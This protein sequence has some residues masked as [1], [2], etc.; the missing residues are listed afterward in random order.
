MRRYINRDRFPPKD[1]IRIEELVNYFDYDYPQ[2][3]GED[4]FSIIT[5]YSDCP[6][7][8]DHKLFHIGLQGKEIDIQDAKPNNLTFLIDVSGSMNSPDKLELLVK[9]FKLLVNNL[10]DDDRVA[11]VVYAGKAGLVLPS[12]LGRNRGKILKALN[13]LRSGGSTAGGAGIKLAYKIAEE[14]FVKEGNNRV[15]LATDGDFN[16]GV[17]STSEMVRLIEENRDKGIFLTVLGFGTGN[18]KD[19]RMEQIADKGNGN[20]YY[21]DNIME[22]KKV[23]INEMGA[24]LF[25]IAKDVKIQVEFNPG[26][27]KAYRLLGYENRMLKK[28]DFNDDKKDAGE[29]GAGHT[30]TALYELILSD[31]ESD[32]EIPDVDDLKYQKVKP[33]SKQNSNELLTVKFRYKKPDGKKSKLIERPVNARKIRFSKTSDH[34]RLS[35]AVAEFGLLLR[36]SKYKESSSFNDVLDLARN[37]KGNDDFGYRAEFIRLAEMVTLIESGR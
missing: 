31:S 21:I 27:V 24:T 14:N 34:F 7:N 4:P 22:G 37:A 15:I 8:E 29:I 26:K 13:K 35:A 11:I 23:F 16:T 12:T 2:P 32:V 30:V 19:G 3:Q 28:E 6:W 20:Y 10:G 17:S 18:L 9:S 1:A 33:S 36:D 5:E 25:T